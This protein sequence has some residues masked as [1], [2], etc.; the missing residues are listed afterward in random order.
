MVSNP[1]TAVSSMVCMKAGILRTRNSVNQPVLSEKSWVSITLMEINQSMIRWCEWH[2]S[3]PYVIHWSM[4]KETLV[5]SM[6]IRLQQCDIQRVD[7]IASPNTC[8]RTSKR[9]QLISNRIL[10]IRRWNQPFCLLDYPIFSS[11]DRMVSQSVWRQEYLL[12]T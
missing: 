1:F 2:R 7:W 12:T 10:T 3:S 6:A 5:Q 4:G 9:K 8:L 11:M